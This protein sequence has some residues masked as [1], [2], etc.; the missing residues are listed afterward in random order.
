VVFD[1]N[2]L[3]EYEAEGVVVLRQCVD[4]IWIEA[5]REAVD[6]DI[7]NPGP[8][9]HSYDLEN[10]GGHF[11]GNLRTWENDPRFCSFC[12]DSTLPAVAAALFGSRK[13]NLLYDQIFVKEPGT[14]IRTRWHNDQPYWPVRG[15]Q[16][17]SFWIALDHVTVESGALEF[18]RRSHHS[19]HWYQ[20]E[21]FGATSGYDG[22][23]RNPKYEPTPNI[24]AEREKHDIVS[25]NLVPGDAYVFHGLTVHSAG[26]NQSSEVRRRG[27]TVRYTGDD[28]VYDSRPGTNAHLRSSAHK[29]GDILDSDQY[30]VVWRSSDATAY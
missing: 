13:V 15:R 9:V 7:E 6:R 28:V 18:I 2:T 25:W 27:Y 11:H 19:G 16:V 3:Q 21:A 14:M 5:L 22:Y 1:L 30:P 8:Y 20:P 26:V 10:N 29:D 4:S 17:A 12:T 24:E 23:E